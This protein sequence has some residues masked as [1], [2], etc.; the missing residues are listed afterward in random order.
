MIPERKPPCGR[1]NHNAQPL[2]NR[3][4]TVTNPI[5]V[6][7]IAKSILGTVRIAGA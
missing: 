2:Q 3:Y 4:K 6:A 7:A 1:H 5:S